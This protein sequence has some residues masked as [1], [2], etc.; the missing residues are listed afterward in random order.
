MVR[1]FFVCAVS[2]VLLAGCGANYHSIFRTYDE[3]GNNIAILDAKQRVILSNQGAKL[4]DGKIVPDPAAYRRYCA[5]PSPDVFSVL[6]S[7]LS[8]SGALGFDG[9]KVDAAANIAA[10]I[11]E[12]GSS[13]VR[14]QTIQTLRELMYRTC[15]RYLSGAIRSEEFKTQ[16]ARDQRIIVSILAI[17]QLTNATR[18]EPVRISV[19]SSASA[20][21]DR[22]KLAQTLADA[23]S[24]LLAQETILRNMEE[25][26]DDAK[27]AAIAAKGAVDAEAGKD[28]DGDPNTKTNQ[29]ELAKLEGK[30]V[31]ADKKVIESQ[32]AVDSQTN[33]VEDGERLVADLDQAS[34]QPDPVS[35]GAQISSF[36]A[37]ANAVS[38]TVAVQVAN[39]VRD[40][41]RLNLEMDEVMLTCLQIL[42]KDGN[43]NDSR[44]FCGQYLT[45]KAEAEVARLSAQKAAAEKQVEILDSIDDPEEFFG[46]IPGAAESIF[47][48]V[49]PR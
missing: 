2:V 48:P 37:S 22:V 16:A 21:E 18:P 46:T 42:S 43:E 36:A 5:E 31:A 6:G 7:S 13:I 17:E 34:R 44:A 35:V 19:S 29:E 45:A 11:S 23:R 8:A 1:K 27:N 15:E 4:V 30:R 47:G 32:A 12:A 33:T 41:V 25:K 3:S 20:G 10:Q 26:R 38:P 28:G 24:R 39:A 14:T 40:I 49:P 9:D